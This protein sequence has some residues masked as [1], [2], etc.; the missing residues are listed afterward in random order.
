M[1]KKTFLVFFFGGTHTIQKVQN[2]SGW[3]TE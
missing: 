3:G 1:Q 2:M